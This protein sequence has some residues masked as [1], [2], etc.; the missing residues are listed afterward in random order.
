MLGTAYTTIVAAV[1]QLASAAPL[2]GSPMVV[3]QTGVGRALVDMLRGGQ[4]SSWIIPVTITGG[5][6][7]HV[8][9][10]GSRHVPKKELV[11]CLQLL[12]Q[13]RRLHIARSL[14]EAKVLV[15]ELQ[16]FQVKITAAANETFGV[17]R[18]GTHDD[19]VLAVAL[20][21]WWAERHP[22]W[23]PDSI[24]VGGP[25]AIGS[26]PEGVFM[27]AGRPGTFREV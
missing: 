17:W 5:Q 23:G 25:S 26:A 19:L 8:A 14:R 7:M 24:G 1:A 6:V 2:H 21:C 22:R 12:L 9:E 13:N 15:R 18:E 3:D 16:Q 10:D 4:T 20:A 27:T 11:T